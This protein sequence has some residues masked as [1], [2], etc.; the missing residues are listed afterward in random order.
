MINHNH[1]ANKEHESELWKEIKCYNCKV[2]FIGKTMYEKINGFIAW[3][4]R[5]L[6]SSEP[7][8]DQDR[9]HVR[10]AIQAYPRGKQSGQKK[11]VLA[12][13]PLRSA[14]QCQT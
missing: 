13:W 4:G 8:E 3:S 12:S 1:K 10:Q 2:Y 11:E 14:R 9:Q 6:H 7:N 5:G